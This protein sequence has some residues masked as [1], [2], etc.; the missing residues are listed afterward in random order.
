LSFPACARHACMGFARLVEAG[1]L[2]RHCHRCTR[3]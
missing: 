2:A 1:T 3:T